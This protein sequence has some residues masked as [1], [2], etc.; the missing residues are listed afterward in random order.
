M[1]KIVWITIL[2]LLFCVPFFLHICHYRNSVVTISGIPFA[3]ILNLD[4]LNDLVIAPVKS[5]I[6]NIRRKK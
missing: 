5:L 3:V 4:F 1:K 6:E 2:L